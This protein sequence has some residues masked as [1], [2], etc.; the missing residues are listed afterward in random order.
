[1]SLRSRKADLWNKQV[2]GNSILFTSPDPA[3]KRLD[4]NDRF[5]VSVIFTGTYDAN[6][7]QF[8]V[9]YLGDRQ[10]IVNESQ[11]RDEFDV[12]LDAQPLSDVTIGVTS[13]DTT[14]ATV[15]VASLTFTSVNWNV[16]Q[17]VTVT[18]V[19]DAVVDGNQR[20]VITLSVVDANSDDALIRWRIKQYWQSPPTTI[21]LS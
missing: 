9:E 7:L 21:P 10:V 12:V 4:E 20:T 18:G 11:T 19:D 15:D 1:M 16:P 3:N 2:T 5:F 17:K 6:L 13:Q 8:D 14:E